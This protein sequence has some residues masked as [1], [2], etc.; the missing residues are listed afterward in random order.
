M[1]R[2]QSKF[3]LYWDALVLLLICYSCLVIP[4]QLVFHQSAEFA[5]NTILHIISLVMLCDIGLNFITSQR[6]GGS[7][8]LDPAAN[9]RHYLHGMFLVDLVANLPLDLL[10]SAMGDPQVGGFSL[11]LLVRLLALFRLARF[12]MILRRWESFSWTNPGY[13]RALKYLG[14]ALILVH[15][16]ACLWFASAYVDGFPQNSWVVAANIQ[17]SDPQSQY[18]RSLYWTVTTMTTVG[19]GDI[20]PNRTVEYLLAI[21]VML[22]GAS[23]YAFIIGGVASLLSNLQAAKNTH[24]EHMESV[25]QYLRSRQVPAYLGDSVHN[26]YEYLWESRKGLNEAA[27]L[28]DLPE[29]LRIEIM[30]HLAKDVLEKVPLFRHCSPFLRNTLLNALQPVTYAPGN[31]LAREGEVGKNLYFINRGQVEILSGANETQHGTMGP[32]DYFG[33]LS[34]VLGEHRSASVRATGYT[35]VLVLDKLRYEQISAEYPEFQQVMK[36]VSVEQSE[37]ASQLLLDGIVL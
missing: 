18:I 8:I 16:I 21:F 23:L 36:K 30:L 4:Y 32:G 27:L 31:Y 33:H 19:Y 14:V 29:S 3:R 35:E 11:I 28:E 22:S 10:A 5:S 24:W 20:S 6:R 25:E 9:R 17:S 37:R 7:E 15:C 34:Q 26:Y 13:L 1:I 2:E 12:F